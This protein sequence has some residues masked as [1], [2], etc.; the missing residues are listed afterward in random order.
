MTADDDRI[1][2]RDTRTSDVAAIVDLAEKGAAMTPETSPADTQERR[3][4][5]VRGMV[6]DA[7]AVSLVAT[8][9]D[10]VCGYLLSMVLP[11]PPEPSGSGGAGPVGYV[12]DFAVA[13]PDDWWAAGTALLGR[14]RQRLRDMGAERV[15]V[16]VD[17]PDPAKR[18]FLWRSGLTL[19]F[20]RYEAR[21]V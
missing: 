8:R 21:L 14:A 5:H 3:H 13:A 18:A 2:I 15:L 1:D 17:A 10:R 12:T 20:E 4:S 19:G 9:D 11:A 16:P 7:T 6:D